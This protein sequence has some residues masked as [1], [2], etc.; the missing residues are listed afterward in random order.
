MRWIALLAL[1][2]PVWSAELKPVTV[3]AWNEYIR[4]TEA[5]LNS[6]KT[7]LWADE[8]PDRA[9][10]LKAGEI[11]VEPFTGKPSRS[12]KGGGLVHDWVGS[13][14]IPGATIEQTLNLVQ[15]YARHKDV[16][17]PEVVDSRIVSH[18]GNDFKIYL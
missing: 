17:K 2:C 1:T 13:A 14:F 6:A 16:Y 10:R 11:L 8:V 12:V 18:T 7:F 3:E 5:R 15:D 4:Q 9:R